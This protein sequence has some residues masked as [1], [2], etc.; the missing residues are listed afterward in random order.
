[1]RCHL[2]LVGLL[3]VSLLLLTCCN[4]RGNFS[5]EELA[6][7]TEGE[8]NS[9]VA[10]YHVIFSDAAKDFLK[11]EDSFSNFRQQLC[12]HFETVCAFLIIE[13]DGLRALSPA[14]LKAFKEKLINVQDKNHG[15]FSDRK[16]DSLIP[17]NSIPEINQDTSTYSRTRSTFQDNTI[18]DFL[19]VLEMIDK[20][21]SLAGCRTTIQRQAFKDGSKYPQDRFHLFQK[22]SVRSTP[23]IK[24][25]SHQAMSGSNWNGDLCINNL[26]ESCIPNKGGNMFV[27]GDFVFL[28]M[29]LLKRGLTRHEVGGDKMHQK[30]S[31]SSVDQRLS[32]INLKSGACESTIIKRLEYLT[33]KKPIWIGFD[34]EQITI[35]KDPEFSIDKRDG[36]MGWQPFYH[37]DLFFH[38]IKIEDNKLFYMIADLSPRWQATCPIGSVYNK[39]LEILR[40]NIREVEKFIN[41]QLSDHSLVGVAIPVPVLCEPGYKCQN[42]P[43]YFYTYVNG[44]LETREGARIYYLPDYLAPSDSVNPDL[45]LE[46]TASLLVNSGCVDQTESILVDSNDGSAVH[47]TV[48][49]SDRGKP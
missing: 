8:I 33:R 21:D 39:S 2:Q 5:N 44:L 9:V 27:L 22:G 43:D 20:G 45:A 11:G 42:P 36:T 46:Y 38:P 40:S 6:S 48:F 1:M 3:A 32:I 35:A 37:I 34:S 47:C 16:L 10:S 14:E 7:T 30:E 28:G 24:A 4:Q 19:L 18:N 17:A 41:A 29:N 13:D 23:I 12:D 49:V 15:F 31:N 26:T 25:F